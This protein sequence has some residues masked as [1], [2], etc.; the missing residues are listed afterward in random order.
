V[1]GATENGV[2]ELFQ[3]FFEE[4][5]RYCVYRLFDKDLADDAALDV[6]LSLTDKW[7][8]LKGRSQTAI[9][10][11]L[12]GTASNVAARYLRDASRQKRIVAELVRQRQ[13]RQDDVGVSDNRL[14]WPVVYE[15]ISRLN[16]KDQSIVTL[17]YFLEYDNSEIAKALGMTRVG[18]RV[19]L[20]RAIRALR[21]EMG[22]KDE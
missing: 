12:Y 5:R 17:R 14:D 16:P 4:V 15:A 18:S 9:R 1:V 19:R 8:K 2:V 22:L 7:P 10:K 3:A 20:H 13:E 21:R 6:F 11:W